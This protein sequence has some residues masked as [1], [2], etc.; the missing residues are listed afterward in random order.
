MTLCGCSDSTEQKDGLQAPT[1]KVPVKL[2]QYGGLLPQIL[3]DRLMAA[4]SSSLYKEHRVCYGMQ[5]SPQ[6][7]CHSVL[8]LYLPRQ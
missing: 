4:V 8:R 5:T 2:L 1:I 3:G 7:G 6:A